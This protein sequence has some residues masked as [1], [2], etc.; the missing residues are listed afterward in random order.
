[1]Q[2]SSIERYRSQI[3]VIQKKYGLTNYVDQLKA[4]ATLFEYEVDSD[5]KFLFEEKM[6]Y[7]KNCIEL[8]NVKAFKDVADSNA[9]L[10]DK[11][12]KN[13]FQVSRDGNIYYVQAL[14]KYCILIDAI[15]YCVL[16]NKKI[17][18]L[19]AED[20]RNIAVR[21]LSDGDTVRSTLGRIKNTGIPEDV[22]Q[23]LIMYLAN[24]G[25]NMGVMDQFPLLRIDHASVS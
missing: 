10:I 17:E 14:S 15:I 23:L 1:M 9:G 20:H 16:R 8:D 2:L 22:R 24:L 21:S 4:I 13:V 3:E 7:L 6:A 19:K 12:G 18:D 25:Y 5:V 11:E